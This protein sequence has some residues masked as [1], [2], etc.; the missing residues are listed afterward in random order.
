[1]KVLGIQTEFFEDLT[2][3]RGASTGVVFEG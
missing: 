2:H 3:P 1:V